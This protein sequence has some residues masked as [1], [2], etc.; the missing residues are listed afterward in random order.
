MVTETAV[1]GRSAR[2]TRTRDAVVAALLALL[3]QG[4]LRPTA[5]RVAERAGVSL[6]SVYVHFDDLEDL[7]CAAARLQFARIADLVEPLPSDGPL[8]ARLDAFVQQRAR[9][10]ETGDAV[11]RA[12][13]LQ[14]PF[15]PT[16]A[17]VLEMGRRAGRA[18][19]AGVFAPERG[20]HD[21]D[22][23]HLLL[24]ALGTT[25]GAATWEG[26]RRGE[27]LEVD[28]ARDVMRRMLRA[29]LEPDHPGAGRSRPPERASARAAPARRRV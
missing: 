8:D 6:R 20:R 21:R 5:R 25:A 15:S 22:E 12:A 14:A 28:A 27:R 9:V 11:R 1:D 29:L 3:E 7:F 10:F 17:R 2:A 23:R 19:I 18:E 26:L 4:D 24:A 16:L 13:A